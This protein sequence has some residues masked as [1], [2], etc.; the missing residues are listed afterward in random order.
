M[1][2]TEINRPAEEKPVIY[3]KT[4][5][6]ERRMLFMTLGLS[7]E[8]QIVLKGPPS[9]RGMGTLFQSQVVDEIACFF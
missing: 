2:T 1:Y 5:R 9:Q 8:I 7:F 3:A 4:Q 6:H